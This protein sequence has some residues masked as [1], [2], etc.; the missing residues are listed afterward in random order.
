MFAAVIPSLVFS[1]RGFYPYEVT[2]QITYCPTNEANNCTFGQLYNS[3]TGI[4]SSTT[5]DRCQCND[6]C[7]SVA[8]NGFPY[9]KGQSLQA[10]LVSDRS[11]ALDDNPS[12]EYAFIINAIFLL[13]ILLHGIL[14]LIEASWSQQHIRDTIFRRLSGTTRRS[15]R[16]TLASK[17][18]HYMGKCVAGFFF[19]SAIVVTVICPPIFISSVIINEITTWDWPVA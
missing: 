13:F 15:L 6:T 1:V 11:T 17:M 7:G 4:S 3:G 19:A 16:K 10:V 8:P 18:R 14:G 9:R 2:N 12:V 5:Y